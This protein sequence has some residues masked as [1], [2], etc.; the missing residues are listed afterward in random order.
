MSSLISR[1]PL[2]LLIGSALLI[3]CAAEGARTPIGVQDKQEALE[4]AVCLADGE[5]DWGELCDFRVC[6]PEG[7]PCPAEGLCRAQRRFY[8]NERLAIPD[9]DPSGVDASILVDRPATSVAR[10]HVG[11]T[12]AHTWRGDLRVVLRSPGGTERVLHDRVGGGQD[13]L[14]IF[15]DVTAAFEGEAAD[16]L[17]TLRVSDH[18]ARDIGHLATWRLEFGFA[19]APTDPPNPATD[20]WATVELPSTESAHPYAN[21][22]DEVTDLRRFSGG[23]DRA[24]IRFNRLETERG[25]DFVHVID[26]DTEE[27]L[28][29]FTGVLEAFTTREYE[30]G[31]LGV[32]L[33]SDYSVTAWGFRVSAVEV[34]GKGCLGD[35]DCPAGTQCPNEVVRC[36]T[37]PCFLSCQPVAPGSE[38]DPCTTSADCGDALY[39]AGDRTCRSV[40]TCGEASDCSLLDNPYPHILC[41]GTAV[42]EA[43]RCGW[44]CTTP[45]E[46]T[47]GD[48]TD[49]GCNTC[50][51]RGGRWLCTERY[52]PPTVGA[53][54]AC[55][56]RTLCEE[57]LVCDRGWTEGPTCTSEQPGIC[58][59]EPAGPIY[60]RGLYAPVC[61]CNG[62]TFE[63]NCQR[64][65]MAAWAHE[66]ECLLDLA[67][68]DANTAG[69]QTT[70]DVAQPASSRRAEVAVRI[71]HSWRGDLVV[72]VES[73]DGS[74]HVLTD[75]QGNSADDFDHRAMI[76]LGTHTV[77]GTWT[78][79]V[80]D[81][82]TYDTGVL[83]HFNVSPR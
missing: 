9:A 17:W 19:A 47:E 37:W 41:L 50:S 29:T 21:D 12:V 35:A 79:H 28:D 24:R 34:F 3:G 83:R 46:C 65:G 54:E 22:T 42:C 1:G 66:G 70:I 18:A 45:M 73:P 51:C 72:W 44:Q 6:I 48:L 74:R 27:T 30:T 77:V 49:D 81:H 40:G 76:D 16:G 58:V 4:G 61:T 31:N 23:A 36:I 14:S 5:C 59:G 52:C 60:C 11:V 39:C 20:I 56:D 82:A 63:G 78:L 67:I 26:L 71:T 7:P 43:G 68:P 69:V 2:T 55:G 80:S 57:G 25:Y 32:R 15:E 75:R 33:V 62:Q 8:D 53:G 38:G 10:L 64:Q 13:N